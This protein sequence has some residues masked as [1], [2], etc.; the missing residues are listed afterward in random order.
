MKNYDLTN[1]NA[2]SDGITNSNTFPNEHAK[3]QL[4]VKPQKIL[5]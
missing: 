1:T 5:E 2:N 3:K 4:R